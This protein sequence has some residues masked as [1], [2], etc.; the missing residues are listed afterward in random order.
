MH[1]KNPTLLALDFDGVLCNGLVEYFQTAWRTYCHIW[2]PSEQIATED[3]AQKFY[4]LRPVIE[5]GWEMPVLVRALVLGIEEEKI[6]DRWQ[7]IA[8]E[9]ITKENRDRAEIG[10][11]LDQTRDEWIAKDLEGWLSLHE[12]YPGVVEKVKQLIASEVKPVIVTTKEGRFVRSLLEKQGIN[13]SPADIIGKECKRPKY[14]TLRILFAASGA[15][16]I[17]WL[18]EDRLK[19]LLAVQKQPDLKEVK[20]FLA[21][22]GYNTTTERE[23]VAQYPPI[24]LLSKSQ[25]CQDFSAWKA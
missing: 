6:F 5:I 10:S 21:D 8:L 11:R 19:T 24:K 23:S 13:L 20:L 15:G 4:R 14:E 12:F 18:V 7:D 22:W 3:L 1:T 25:F 2:Q 16:T 17:I 9:I